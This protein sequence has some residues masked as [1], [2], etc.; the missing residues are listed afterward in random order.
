MFVLDVDRDE[1][2]SAVPIH[3]TLDMYPHFLTNF[4]VHRKHE[5]TV[6]SPTEILSSFA[7]DFS[8]IAQHF[9]YTSEASV[10]RSTQTIFIVTLKLP[11]S[12]IRD[13]LTTG[14]SI[15]SPI[16]H[17]IWTEVQWKCVH[18]RSCVQV[19]LHPFKPLWTTHC[20]NVK[21]SKWK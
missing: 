13:T 20:T 3:Q 16:S 12:T 17:S 19:H 11:S 5:S 21:T 2:F 8:S 7:R 4:A 9:V 6:P 18:C 15:K 10:Q 1:L 14:F